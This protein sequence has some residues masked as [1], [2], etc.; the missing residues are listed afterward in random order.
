MGKD[1]DNFFTQITNLSQ[2]APSQGRMFTASSTS[3]IDTHKTTVTKNVPED[4][5]AFGFKA[6]LIRVI[7]NMVHKDKACQDLVSDS[8][9]DTDTYYQLLR[10]ITK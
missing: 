2:V 7:A 9:Q 10:G 3:D 4:H 5:P 6:G 1:S 8:N